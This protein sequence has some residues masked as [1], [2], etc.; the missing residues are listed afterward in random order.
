MRMI[1]TIWN[2][3]EKA[4]FQRRLLGNIAS[5]Q[6]YRPHYQAQRHCAIS[7]FCKKPE[8]PL[9][10]HEENLHVIVQGLRI[11]LFISVIWC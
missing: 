9:I 1:C 2:L 8:L 11:F 4:H 5:D 10:Y 6:T 7:Q 3:E